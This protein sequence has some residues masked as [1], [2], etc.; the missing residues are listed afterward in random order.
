[1]S[2]SDS[3][4]TQPCHVKMTSARDGERDLT[5]LS[6]P[7]LASLGGGLYIFGNPALPTCQA[8]AIRDHLLAA[9][10]RGDVQI[11]GTDDAGTCP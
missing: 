10:F 7:A 3:M 4:M 2:D 8:E 5:A 9:G 1:M 11:S 6:L